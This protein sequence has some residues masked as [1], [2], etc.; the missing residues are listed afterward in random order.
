[1]R[2]ALSNLNW[3]RIR[4]G[5]LM[6]SVPVPAPVFFLISLL[7]GWACFTLYFK[8]DRNT[9]T[10]EVLEARTSAIESHLQNRGEPAGDLP[11]D[12]GDYPEPPSS[13]VEM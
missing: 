6:R 8:I 4:V 10:L 2:A 11:D 5:L 13:A 3:K 12:E 1:M 7:I 9:R